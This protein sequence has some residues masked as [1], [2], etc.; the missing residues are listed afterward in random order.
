MQKATIYQQKL[1]GNMLVEPGQTHHFILEAI[2]LQMRQIIM[3]IIPTIITQKELTV[4]ELLMLVVL[5][6]MILG[7]LICMVM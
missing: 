4:K 7:Y 1:N 3:G 2:S 6:Q 5:N